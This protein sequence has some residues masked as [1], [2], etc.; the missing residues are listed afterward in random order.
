MDISGIDF[1]LFFVVVFL[2]L[3]FP[4]KPNLRAVAFSHHPYSNRQALESFSGNLKWDV[5]W[6]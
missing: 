4:L 6:G 1:L 5:V 3:S 2:H